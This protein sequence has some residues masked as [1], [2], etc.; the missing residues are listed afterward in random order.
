MN[1][2]QFITTTIILEVIL[3]TLL[4]ANIVFETKRVDNNFIYRNDAQQFNQHNK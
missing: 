2:K 4:T 1:T 3:I